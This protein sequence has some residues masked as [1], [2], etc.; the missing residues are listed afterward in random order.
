MFRIKYMYSVMA[1]VVVL[2]GF[3]AFWVWQ[4]R[5]ELPSASKAPNVVVTT[6]NV[7]SPTSNGGKK[8]VQIR[9]KDGELDHLKMIVSDMHDTMNRLT[10]YGAITHY[11]SKDS[12]YWTILPEKELQEKA[13]H[14]LD[15]MISQNLAQDV[16]N[17]K[18]AL[19]IAVTNKDALALK[20]AHRIIHDLDNH[21]LNDKTEGTRDK[22][23]WHATGT[24]EGNKAYI[25]T[26]L[27]EYKP[28]S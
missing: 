24:L 12:V 17:F 5:G 16:K 19:Q 1:A 14:A 13:D 26:W 11:A 21:V 23:Y 2:A 25:D 3:Y 4:H 20:V 7:D 27:A 28:S 18:Q 22:D 8:V 10:G 9:V 15:K 6:A